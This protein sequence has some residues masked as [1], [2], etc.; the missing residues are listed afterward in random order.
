M[1]KFVGKFFR[2]R[3][4]SNSPYK[5][6]MIRS[7]PP[8]GWVTLWPSWSNPVERGITLKIGDK[9][10]RPRKLSEGRYIFDVPA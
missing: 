4:R 7:C 1:F 5:E 9:L 2:G 8:T 3:S 6:E 10:F